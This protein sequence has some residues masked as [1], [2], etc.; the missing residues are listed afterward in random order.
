MLS[1][2]TTIDCG[3]RT[4]TV[5]AMA[6]VPVLPEVGVAWSVERCDAA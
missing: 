2:S 5:I 3:L 6:A 4:A 1:T